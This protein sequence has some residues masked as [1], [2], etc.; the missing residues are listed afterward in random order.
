M[1]KDADLVK[2]FVQA[3]IDLGLDWGSRG[4]G[5]PSPTAKDVVE[6]LDRLAY[7]LATA[8]AEWDRTIEFNSRLIARS[9][10]ADA[11]LEK[12]GRHSVFCLSVSGVGDCDCGL[13]AAKAGA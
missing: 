7:R 10:A 3:A 11:A 5:A 12:F 4:G 6:A 8:E 13:D 1:N 9:E 2:G